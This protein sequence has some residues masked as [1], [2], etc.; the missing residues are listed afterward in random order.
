MFSH[1]NG[2]DSPFVFTEILFLSPVYF[3][4]GGKQT[5]DSV[6]SRND[7]VSWARG[8]IQCPVCISSRSGL[9]S[10]VLHPFWYDHSGWTVQPAVCGSQLLQ[11]PLRS[12]F[13]HLLRISSAKLPQTEP[14]SYW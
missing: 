7:A 6:W 10:F 2:N 5:C 3:F 8:Q 9:G 11:E 13:L 4:P 12:W 14:S 1:R